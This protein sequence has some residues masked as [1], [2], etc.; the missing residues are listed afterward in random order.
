MRIAQVAPLYEAVP[1]KAYGGTERIVAHI[2]DALVG[3]GHDVTLFASADAGA[4]ARL[5]PCRG[6]PIRLDL[7]LKSDVAAHL[8]MLDEV[9]RRA[10]AFDAIHF[11]IDLLHMPVFRDL[12]GRTLTTLHGRLDIRDLGPFYARFPEFPLVSISNAQRRPLPDANWI[13]TVHH[14]LPTDLYRPQPSPAGDY[15]AFLGRIAPEKRPDL[16]IE[17]AV[18]AGMPL[19]IAAKVDPADRDYFERRIEPL[20]DHPLIEYVGE[21]G[22]ARKGEFLGHARALLFPIDW[23]EPFGLV[24]IEA[25]ACGTPVIAFR[26]GSVREVLEHGVTGLLVKGVDEAVAAIADLDRLDRGRIRRTFERRFT[27]EVM[28]RNYVRLYEM[29][30][31]R[32]PVRPFVI[33]PAVRQARRRLVTG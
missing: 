29:G 13:A 31:G 15:L 7:S 17:I 18:R 24:M 26:R 6:Q 21:I 8:S 33:V 9:R 30:L 5:V 3:L 4:K 11:H 1:P 25:M 14:G 32:E 23:P 22:E 28:A 27:A 2:S 16:A 10:A 19:K 12:A 20:L